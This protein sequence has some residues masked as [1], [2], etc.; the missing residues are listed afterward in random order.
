MLSVAAAL[1]AALATGVGSNGS[2][3]NGHG[4]SCRCS[5]AT[6]VLVA[7]GGGGQQQHQQQHDTEPAQ[8]CK[9]C[10]SEASK[11]RHETRDLATGGLQSMSK[12]SLPLFQQVLVHARGFTIS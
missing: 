4:C 12:H 8:G 6:R 5:K 3:S 1:A 9:C 2:G 10:F 7:T 11:A